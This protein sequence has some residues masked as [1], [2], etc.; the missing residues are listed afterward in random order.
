MLYNIK[1]LKMYILLFVILTLILLL[2]IKPSKT[3]IDCNIENYEQ[4]YENCSDNPE[5][6]CSPITGSEPEYDPEKWNGNDY[7]EDSH[8]CYAYSLNDINDDLT[9]LCKNSECRYINPQPGHHCGMTKRVN[10]DETTCDKLDERIKCDNPSIFDTTFE[11]KCPSGYYKIGLAVQPNKIYHFYRQGKNGYWDHKDGG[12]EATNLD[13]SHKVI[14]NPV[15]ANRDYGQ[16]HFYKWCKF[17]CVPSNE[18]GHTYYARNDYYG[19]K[20]HYKAQYE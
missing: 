16:N 19:G 20:L 2:F 4:V 17:Y 11:E 6:T 9:K 7:I 5:N 8:N 1:H 10:Y 14:V 13:A 12:R 3:Q 15:D 18:F